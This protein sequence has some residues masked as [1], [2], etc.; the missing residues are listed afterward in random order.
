METVHLSWAAA[1]GLRNRCRSHSMSSLQVGCRRFFGRYSS[2]NQ[3]IAAWTI[4][5]ITVRLQL[6][7][8]RVAVRLEWGRNRVS[9][10][11]VIMSRASQ[12]RN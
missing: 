7:G 1:A 5:L 10:I 6:I 8:F 3:A 4:L 12:G 9:L 2:R 11:R